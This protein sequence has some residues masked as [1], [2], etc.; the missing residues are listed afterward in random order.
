MRKIYFLLIFL[1][2]FGSA[3]AQTEIGIQ[4]GVNRSRFWG[5]NYYSQHHDAITCFSFGG[6]LNKIISTHF[7]LSSGI[8]YE[9]TGSGINNLYFENPVGSSDFVKGDLKME[10]NYLSIPLVINYDFGKTRAFG[11]GAGFFG[12]YLLS[13]NN[14]FDYDTPNSGL[15]EKGS[16]RKNYEDFNYG[17]TANAHYRLQLP[18]NKSL[19]FSVEDHLGLSN[20]DNQLNE[21]KK[22]NSI[23]IYASFLVN[24]RGSKK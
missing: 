7:S 8:L 14:K 15:P 12:S 24:L 17:F 11:L 21:K 2:L 10:L 5:D 1:S 3:F 16:T 23:G 19:V 18:K 9:R 20:L 6:V 22:T 4:A 13:A